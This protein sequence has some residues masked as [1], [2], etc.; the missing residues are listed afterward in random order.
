MNEIVLTGFKMNTSLVKALKNA[1]PAILE[2]N[3]HY[4]WLNDGDMFLPPVMLNM[5]YT[6]HM[7]YLVGFAIN[8]H[9]GNAV[10]S[11]RRVTIH[12]NLC[13]SLK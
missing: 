7:F 12:T 9:T 13:E 5:A 11:S 3:R 10:F 6:A 2:F 4:S 1:G 8:I